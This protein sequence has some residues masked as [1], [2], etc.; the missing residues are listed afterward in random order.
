LSV[1]GDSFR[2]APTGGGGK[3]VKE[4]SVLVFTGEFAE[5]ITI[6]LVENM[7]AG[8][9]AGAVVSTSKRLRKK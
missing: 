1:E 4:G 8:D 2:L 5:P 3:L 7:I 9:R 6:E